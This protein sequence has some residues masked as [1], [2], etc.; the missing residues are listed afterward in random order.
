MK[1]PSIMNIFIESFTTVF[2][3]KKIQSFLTSLIFS[4]VQVGLFFGITYLTFLISWFGNN[5]KLIIFVLF[6]CFF[7]YWVI[8]TSTF[9]LHGFFAVNQFKNFW[10]IFSLIHKKYHWLI[11]F[12][13]ASAVIPMMLILLLIIDAL[14]FPY[15]FSQRNTE[16]AMLIFSYSSIILLC[17]FWALTWFAIGIKGTF[18]IS[19][20]KTMILSLY[21]WVKNLHRILAIL[22]FFT[23][24]GTIWAYAL[25]F[26]KD[27]A[28]ND[29]VR[30]CALIFGYLLLNS[31]LSCSSALLVKKTLQ[32]ENHN[33][34]VNYLL[35]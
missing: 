9:A 13:F 29:V 24:L 4:A 31:W 11:C 18:N 23:I 30:I 25:G 2:I 27:S 20:R 17:F 21:L 3:R 26:Q 22:I 8:F 5:E 28:W 1:K 19:F 10:R 15:F 32:Y 16:I 6:F 33:A 35:V 7:F 34:M 12:S 14:F